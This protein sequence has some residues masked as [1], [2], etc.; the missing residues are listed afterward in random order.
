MFAPWLTTNTPFS[1][2]LAASLA[3]ISVWVA[4]G[5]A[6]SA[7]TLHSGLASAVGSNGVKVAPGKRSAY[8]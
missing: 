2:I 3:L 8:S 4:L 5:N 1:S 6:Q 7:G